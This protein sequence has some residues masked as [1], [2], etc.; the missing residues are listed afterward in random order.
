MK[1]MDLKIPKIIQLPSGSFST[2][3]MVDGQRHTITRDTEEECAAAVAAIK[4]GAMQAKK[5]ERA[6]II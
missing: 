4:Y 5:S 1:K 3:I 2:K 6:A